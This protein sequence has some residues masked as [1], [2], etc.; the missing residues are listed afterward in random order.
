MQENA[1]KTCPFGDDI[2][3]YMYDEMTLPAQLEFEL[4]LSAC[5]VCTD[6]FAAVSVARF[7]TYD[8]KRLEFDPM[9]TP[10][11]VTPYPATV[12]TLGERLS[13]WLSWV[14]I[15]PAAAAVL[16]GFGV[17]YV[18]FLNRGVDIDH[19]L[20]AVQVVQSPPSTS[21]RQP[22]G[23][24]RLTKG[25]E[26]RRGNLAAKPVSVA[27]KQ[28]LQ[29][30]R[31]QVAKRVGPQFRLTNNVADNVVPVQI[32][33]APR[34]GM[35]DEEADRSLRLADLFDETNPPPQR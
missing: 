30:P 10:Q 8:W 34:L 24:P 29:I 15:V 33:R 27:L 6:E 4:H 13:A 23:D 7:E 21:V 20:A 31:S 22:V 35:N 14:T 17:L 18:L 32:K 2:V 12:V 16:I 3:S 25:S 11:I 9:T 26:V 5:Q 28:K 1:Q 19:S